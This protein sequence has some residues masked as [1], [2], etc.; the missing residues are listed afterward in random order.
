V[1]NLRATGLSRLYFHRW[2]NI[3]SNLDFQGQSPSVVAKPE[4]KQTIGL[5]FANKNGTSNKERIGIMKTMTNKSNWIGCGVV[6]LVAVAGN[7]FASAPAYK[8]DRSIGQNEF[9]SD[10]VSIA[11]DAGDQLHVLLRDGTVVNCDADGKTT[12]SFKADMTSAPGAMA[13]A[14]GKLYLLQTKKN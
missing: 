5:C 6:A 9:K 8:V 13:L 1:L 4:Q 2:R 7:L 14:D 11:V 10:P 3:D 12:G